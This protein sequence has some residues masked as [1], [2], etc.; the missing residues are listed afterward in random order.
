MGHKP[1]DLPWR[2]QEKRRGNQAWK[3]DSVERTQ[4]GAFLSLDGGAYESEC[5]LEPGHDGSHW[6]GQMSWGRYA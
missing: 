1:W 2:R 4:C 5:Q 6:D 3:G